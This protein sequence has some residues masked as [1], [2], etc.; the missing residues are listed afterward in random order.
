MTVGV[1]P[2]PLDPQQRR[3]LRL[4]IVE[5]HP[6]V[7]GSDVGP[8]AVEA[9]DCDRCGLEARL[10]AVCG[11]VPWEAIG[12][13]CAREL[14]T[15]AWCEGHAAEGT[16]ALRHLAALPEDADT[17]TRLWWVATGEIRVDERTTGDLLTALPGLAGEAAARSPSP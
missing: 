11:P 6:W 13:R 12:R 2:N 9:G 1:M 4:A 14:G 17:V 7:E 8:A 5:R 16:A 15:Q 10:V 3:R